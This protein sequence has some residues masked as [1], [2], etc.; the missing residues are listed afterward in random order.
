MN[1]LGKTDYATAITY[2]LSSIPEIRHY[3]LL[4]DKL[5]EPLL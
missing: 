1:N 5:K 2:L 4:R 3:F